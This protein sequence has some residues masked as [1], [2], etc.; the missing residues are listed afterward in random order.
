LD[1]DNI[2]QQVKN[3]EATLL[4]E[5]QIQNYAVL[6]PLLEKN[7][8]T[9][10]LFEVRSMQMRSQPG[11]VCFPGG[12]VE[13]TDKDEKHG[14]LRETSEEL[15]IPIKQI[16]D[17]YPLDVMALSLDRIIYPFIGKLPPHIELQPN[18]HEVAEIFTIPVNFLLENKPKKYK[19]TLKAIPEEDF[20]Y[21][22]IVGGKDYDWS[23]RTIYQYFY[24]YGEYVIWGLTAKIILNFLHI[25]KQT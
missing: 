16:S 21:H 14:A 5:K 10:L 20:P 18:K 1:I 3:Y 2:I 7:G 9:H 6:L 22:L 17:V 19:V 13:K 15:G 11:D 4:N 24:T 12:K 25:L 23:H 8:E